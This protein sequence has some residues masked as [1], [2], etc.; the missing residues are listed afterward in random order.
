MPIIHSRVVLARTLLC[1]F[2]SLGS[3]VAPAT[4]LAAPPSC[5]SIAKGLLDA[6]V[7]AG[8]RSS[9]MVRLDAG[10]TVN[11]LLSGAQSSVVLV[12]GDGAPRVLVSADGERM[13]TFA[14]PTSE[15]YVF[16]VEAGDAAATTVGVNCTRATGATASDTLELPVASLA[17]TGS[18]TARHSAFSL[19]FAEMVANSKDQSAIT[20]WAGNRAAALPFDTSAEFGDAGAV[21]LALETSTE[22]GPDEIG[23]VL[24]R[25]ARVSTEDEGLSE[26]QVAMADTAIPAN[27]VDFEFHSDAR[28]ST[29]SAAGKGK[30][31][32]AAVVAAADTWVTQLNDAY[33]GGSSETSVSRPAA[34]ASSKLL[35]PPMALGAPLPFDAGA[36]TVAAVVTQ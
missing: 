5:K 4:L 14:A 7:P 8:Q 13:A 36:S 2:A 24:D 16:A 18:A 19:G 27:D 9:R 35:P 3:L 11:F 6:E 29:A 23:E 17:T 33:D 12:A 31:S 28:V 22:I 30:R 32:S 34:V 10:D 25:V 1:T 20:R 15:T 26:V 21:S